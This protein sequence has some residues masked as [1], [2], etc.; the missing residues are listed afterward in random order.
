M[1]QEL[2]AT[3]EE[4]IAA[5]PGG[6][7]P[8]PAAAELLAYRARRLDDA[9]AAAVLEH[10]VACRACAAAL[11]DLEALGGPATDP[12]VPDYGT[13]AAWR[14]LAPRL[15]DEDAADSGSPSS[16]PPV[17]QPWLGRLAAGLAVVTL[18][19]GVWGARSSQS[20]D[21]LEARIAALEAP[22]ANPAVVYLDPPIRSD[23]GTAEVSRDAGRAILFLTPP[24]DVLLPVYRVEIRD[25]GG[26]VQAAV[27]GLLDDGF[28]SLRFSLATDTLAAGKYR[29]ELYDNGGTE[30]LASYPLEV[31]DQAPPASPDAP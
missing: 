29:I 31:L 3:L 18:A 19:L 26:R 25:D 10:L 28:G 12:S 8:H 13:A 22:R 24:Q 17:A 21:A 16:R 1:S 27:R 20:R 14:T 4:L 6:R 15:A 5:S 23:E 2:E 9:A 11:V 30:L 7:P